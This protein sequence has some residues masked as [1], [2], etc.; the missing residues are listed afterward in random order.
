M[1]LIM[2]QSHGVQ[3]VRRFFAL[4][5]QSTMIEIKCQKNTEHSIQDYQN[6]PTF[7][8][9]TNNGCE[10]HDKIMNCTV[11]FTSVHAVSSA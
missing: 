9:E 6:L 10:D 7:V 4:I 1:T 2:L 3:I 11:E 8:L 5:V